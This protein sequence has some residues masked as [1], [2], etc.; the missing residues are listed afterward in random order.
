MCETNAFS[1]YGLAFYYEIAIFRDHSDQILA[2]SHG[3]I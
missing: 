1:Q 2:I 3:S